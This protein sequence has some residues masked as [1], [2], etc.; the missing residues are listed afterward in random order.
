M[1]NPYE[2]DCKDKKE[3]VD[4]RFVVPGYKDLPADFF[5]RKE[6]PPP[7]HPMYYCRTCEALTPSSGPYIRRCMICS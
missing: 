4:P 7:A 3:P 1:C 2:R 6:P 5:V